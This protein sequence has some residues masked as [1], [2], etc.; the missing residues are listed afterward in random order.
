[1]HYI[2]YLHEWPK[3]FYLPRIRFVKFIY[4][5]RQWISWITRGSCTNE[6]GHIF[7]KQARCDII[8]H[9]R[10]EH[11]PWNLLSEVKYGIHIKNTQPHNPLV[12]APLVV[13]G[14]AYVHLCMTRAVPLYKG[15]ESHSPVQHL[16]LAPLVKQLNFSVDARERRVSDWWRGRLVAL[17]GSARQRSSFHGGAV[18]I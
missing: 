13:Q 16:Q 8:D 12:F 1:M 11:Y 6:T 15:L 18:L 10:L 5:M 14:V 9:G 4:I 3:R 2:E 17:Q 7:R